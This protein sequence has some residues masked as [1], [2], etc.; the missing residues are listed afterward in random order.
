[1]AHLS[2]GHY[3]VT[4]VLGE[5]GA[6]VADPEAGIVNRSMDYLALCYSGALLQFEIPTTKG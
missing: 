6:V 4:H 3:V 2:S 1:M 5:A